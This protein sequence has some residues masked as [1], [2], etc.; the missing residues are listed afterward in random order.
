MHHP[1]L[2]PEP[3]KTNTDPKTANIVG[4]SCKYFLF[5]ELNSI[6]RVTVDLVNR[7]KK[8]YGTVTIN[9]V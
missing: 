8:H 7:Y 2:G 3:H 4:T 5:R 9:Q 1:K 6:S